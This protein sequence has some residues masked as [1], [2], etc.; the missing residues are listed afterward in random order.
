MAWTNI[1]A[2][3]EDEVERMI[4]KFQQSPH[5]LQEGLLSKI[6]FELAKTDT[7]Y[8]KKQFERLVKLTSSYSDEERIKARIYA[9]YFAANF[10]SPHEKMMKLKEAFQLSEKFELYYLMARVKQNFGYAYK[11]LMYYDSAMVCFLES[12]FYF[13]KAGKFAELVAITHE[14]GDFYYH[15]DLLERAESVYNEVL[16]LKGESIAWKNFRYVVL[17]NNLGLIEIKRKNYK[18][19]IHYF[20]T[21]LNYKLSYRGGEIDRSDSTAIAYI[22]MKLALSNLMLKNYP[23][24]KEYL[25]KSMIFTQSVQYTENLIYLLIIKGNLFYELSDY[26]TALK[27][28]QDAADLNT[29]HGDAHTTLELSSAFANIYDKLGDHKNSLFW[30]KNYKHL[31]DSISLNKKAAASLQ[32]KAETENQKNLDAIGDLQNEKILFTGIAL[33]LIISLSTVLLILIRLRKADKMLI[34]K[35]IEVV[36][37]ENKYQHPIDTENKIESVDANSPIAAKQ[38]EVVIEPDPN[39]QFAIIISKLEKVMHDKKLYRNPHLTLEELAH[40]VESNRNYLSKSINQ[41][42]K[43][44]FSQYINMLRVKESIRLVT[45]SGGTPF[46]IEGLGREVGFNNRTSFI[47]A[48]KK[49]SG[50][51]PSYFLK[52]IGRAV[53]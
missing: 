53:N 18:K 16:N 5:E 46:T 49:Y 17:K 35:N 47:L 26:N 39:I 43:L 36:K 40:E 41:V 30:F 14:I 52:S 45:L 3:I 50:V 21:S 32:L 27:Y 44:N 10:G 28:L 37:I 29:A 9:L 22:Y 24:A 7:A 25:D 13:E 23:A 51:T 31:S 11:N 15:A 6:F 42:Y 12:K 4:V 8:A 2:Q 20:N 33:F 48:F 34:E 1:S 19:A 38:L